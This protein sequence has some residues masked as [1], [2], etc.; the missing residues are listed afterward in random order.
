MTTAAAPTGN[1]AI[2]TPNLQAVFNTG[3]VIPPS[4]NP[5]AV[6]APLLYYSDTTVQIGATLKFDSPG[7]AWP[8][9]WL[10]GPQTW[11]VPGRPRQR[12]ITLDFS[13]GG[14]II[15]LSSASPTTGGGQHGLCIGFT[16][17]FNL[18]SPYVQ[19]INNRNLFAVLIRQSNNG[20]VTGGY[21]SH[22]TQYQGADGF[23]LV[24]NCNNIE[25]SGM[26]IT[27]AD[28][29][30]SW[31]LEN[32]LNE[33][34]SVIQN[35]AFRG[36]S[37]INYGHSSVKG[38]ILSTVGD[39]SVLQDINYYD[40]D[41]FTIPQHFGA[42]APVWIQNQEPNA[43]IQRIGIYG[44]RLH[45]Q[46]PDPN[47]QVVGPHVTLAGVSNFT[48]D[49][50]DLEFFGRQVLNAVNCPNLKFRPSACRLTPGRTVSTPSIAI[51]LISLQSCPGYDI[52]LSKF[53]TVYPG[54][55][56]LSA[57]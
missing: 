32:S 55:T 48:L 38:L 2:D 5:Y 37:L 6:N 53:S 13:L 22:I 20:T 47:Q 54:Q 8:N 42:G 30:T 36:C 7:A 41:M 33:Q 23:H 16:D 49:G 21:A 46:L 50:T 4:S 57:S 28:D 25:V 19:G 34:N 24:G 14:Q 52:D 56:L 43:I 9:T 11:N 51:P 45:I 44:G 29:S 3:G 26:A 10:V 40:C 12:N 1:P 18:I 39:E 31:T 27:S 17:G 15:G 35:V